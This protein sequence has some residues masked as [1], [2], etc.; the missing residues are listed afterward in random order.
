[1]SIENLLT[2]DL[3]DFRRFPEVA[4]VSPADI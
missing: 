2:F 3:E 1:M 4:A